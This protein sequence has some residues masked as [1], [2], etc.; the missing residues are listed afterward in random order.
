MVIIKL[1]KRM[2]EHCGHIINKIVDFY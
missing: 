2:S 1:E